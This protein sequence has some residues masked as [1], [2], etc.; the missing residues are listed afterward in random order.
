MTV[1]PLVL[2]VCYLRCHLRKDKPTDMTSLEQ[3]L[4]ICFI[5]VRMC[6][7]IHPTEFGSGKHS[8]MIFGGFGFVYMC[9][10]FKYKLIPYFKN[11]IIYGVLVIRMDAF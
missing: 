9:V 5:A 6:F 3:T 2:S 1:T 11:G 4:G 7:K 10:L 8:H